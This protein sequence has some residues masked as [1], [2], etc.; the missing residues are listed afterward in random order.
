MNFKRMLKLFIL[1]TCLVVSPTLQN[2]PETLN[3]E[4]ITNFNITSPGKGPSYA[5][6]TVNGADTVAFC[7]QSLIEG[8]TLNKKIVTYTFNSENKSF[9]LL[10]ENDLENLYEPFE[11]CNFISDKKLLGKFPHTM[12]SYSSFLMDTNGVISE[13]SNNSWSVSMGSTFFNDIVK[14]KANTRYYLIVDR[15]EGVLYFGDSAKNEM[16]TR[17]N[18]KKPKYAIFDKK[19]NT[20]LIFAVD[21]TKGFIRIDYTSSQLI[22]IG[23]AKAIS[24]DFGSNEAVGMEIGGINED[25]L[26]IAVENGSPNF[27]NYYKIKEEE[28][29]TI[30]TLKGKTEYGKIPGN[31]GILNLQGM[32]IYIFSSYVYGESIELSYTSL[33]LIDATGTEEGNS[34]ALTAVNIGSNLMPGA[35][36]PFVTSIEKVVPKN[37]ALSGNRGFFMIS[38]FSNPGTSI[39]TNVEAFAY[40]YSYYGCFHS[41]S[42]CRGGEIDHCTVCKEGYKLGRALAD[43]K[44]FSCILDTDG[45]DKTK[46][47]D[48]IVPGCTICKGDGSSHCARCEDGK[49]VFI[50][51][52]DL[53]LST[54]K[55]CETPNCAYCMFTG[56]IESSC[57]S[58]NVYAFNKKE[59]VGFILLILLMLF[60]VDWFK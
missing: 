7:S 11:G 49:G 30:G 51:P 38:G 6:A 15:N 9:Q 40:I 44:S 45:H 36:K 46:C 17:D 56:N 8:Q 60:K 21:S 59:L 27:M 47:Q 24:S 1:I 43:S 52:T 34:L 37:A 22:E 39:G 10:K 35:T 20:S 29:I 42:K 2:L 31:Q 5:M 58:N 19:P 32:N 41:C 25:R 16:P 4:L 53:D 57:I 14:T 28:L 48:K 55:P 23:D 26:M 54:C 13:D 33:L 3:V 50:D 12:R 18:N